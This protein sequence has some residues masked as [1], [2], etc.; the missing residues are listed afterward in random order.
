MQSSRTQVRIV[1]TSRLQ[2]GRTKNT[3]KQKRREVSFSSSWNVAFTQ[4]FTKTEEFAEF[5][6]QT[7]YFIFSNDN[8][9]AVVARES[10]QMFVI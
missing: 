3:Q 1:Y 7:P 8:A 4:R 9:A 10:R 6:H 5:A 2:I